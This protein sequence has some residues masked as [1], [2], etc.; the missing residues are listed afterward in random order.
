MGRRRKADGPADQEED[1]LLKRPAPAWSMFAGVV[2][3]GRERLVI[4][5]QHAGLVAALS[6]M[7]PGTRHQA[8]AGPLMGH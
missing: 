6:L 1:F 8:L 2:G 4:S 3:D 7:F 5:D